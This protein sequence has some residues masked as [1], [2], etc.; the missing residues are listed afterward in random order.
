M[1]F[2]SFDNYPMSWKPVLDKSEK[3]LYKSLA[4]QLESDIEKGN[5]KLGIKLPPQRELADFLDINLS[6][7][8]KAFK[9]CSDKGLLNSGIG[10][11]TFVA[12]HKIENMVPAQKN[13]IDMGSIM[14]A[15]GRHDE[16]REIIAE[17][18]EEDYFD[19][20]L[21]YLN[22]DEYWQ[23]E[24]AAR[25]LNDTGCDIEA[26]R[27]ITAF[28]GQNAI[29]NI[30]A[31][32][33]K[34][35]DRLG[36]D[37]LVYPGVITLA[38]TMGIRLVPIKQKNGEMSEEGILK[39]IKNDGIKGLYIVPNC[40]NPTNHYMSEECRSMIAKVAKEEDIIVI[41]DSFTSLIMDRQ[42]RRRSIFNRA[43][44]NAIFILSLSKSIGPG[45]RQAYVAAPERYSAAISDAVYN[46][47]FDQSCLLNEVAARLIL[48]GKYEALLERRCSML[49]ERN[50]ETKEILK[51]YELYGGS[52]A[53]AKWLVLP[54]GIACSEIEKEAGKRGV[55][56]YGS[57]HF[58]VGKEAPVSGIRLAISTPKTTEELRCA[59]LILRD[60]LEEKRVML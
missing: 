32:L 55:L 19:E 26:N 22:G 56:I 24:A 29:A 52:K 54:K 21:Q 14:P 13:V 20:T 58:A 37:P 15:L 28:G 46:I 25:L 44:E 27:I 3:P 48:S 30:F 1:P 42:L 31:A 51:G 5:L 50:R 39:A 34:A 33:F 38:G 11:G 7:V 8:A 9:L 60:I 23:K 2:N 10:S 57:E 49:E 18:L 40:Q 53:L 6:T 12:Y 43:P 41:E 36:V 4:R 17:L 45:L 47:N 35:G 16:I 59:L